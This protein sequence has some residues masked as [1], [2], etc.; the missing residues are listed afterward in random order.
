MQLG[1][2]SSLARLRR[3]RSKTADPSGQEHL[4][5]APK[6]SR[7]G[8]GALPLITVEVDYH[9]TMFYV[10]RGRR[11]ANGAAAQTLPRPLFSACP[12]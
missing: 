6:R 2:V 4:E 9:R 7:V 5:S 12:V 11:Y 8:P 10:V 1:R 3:H